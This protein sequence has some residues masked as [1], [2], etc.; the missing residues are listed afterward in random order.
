[1]E[2]GSREA[3]KGAVEA[4]LGVAIV[5]GST[6]VKEL[7]LGDLVAVPLDLPLHRKLTLVY[8]QEKFRTKLLQSFLDFVDTCQLTQPKPK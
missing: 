4:G 3:I 1:M 6:I 5:S 7:K 2:L 8:A